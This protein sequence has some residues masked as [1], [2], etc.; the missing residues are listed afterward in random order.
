MLLLAATWMGFPLWMLV[1]TA[2]LR[3]IPRSVLEAAELDG[4]GR[5]RTFRDVTLPLLLPLLGAAFVIRGIT[6][7]NQFYLFRV[8]RAAGRDD[9]PVHV[10]LQRVRLHRRRR[11][12]SRSARR[13]TS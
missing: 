8:L 13:S 6:A 1:A 10:Q 4:A 2:G 3:T 12:C 7:F 11:A 5:W 9:D